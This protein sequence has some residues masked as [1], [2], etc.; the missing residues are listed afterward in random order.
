MNERSKGR[1][2]VVLGV[3]CM[4]Q[5][6]VIFWM[7]FAED[8]HS[9]ISVLNTTVPARKPSNLTSQVISGEPQRLTDT[10]SELPTKPAVENP[11]S[12]S[13]LSKLVGHSVFR[14]GSLQIN[15]QIAH[16]L[17]LSR[18]QIEEVND[19]LMRH[20]EDY[21]NASVDKAQLV[22]TPEGDTYFKISPSAELSN[23]GDRLRSNLTDAIG[24]DAGNAITGLAARS[25]FFLSLGKNSIDI[26]LDDI[27]NPDGVQQRYLIATI[28]DSASDDNGFSAH[29]LITP[30]AKNPLYE[31]LMARFSSQ[32]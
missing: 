6:T 20:A 14:A 24:V 9:Q 28:G 1:L 23:L 13:T 5:T 19:I 15:P 31:S 26:Y 12:S 27:V 3:V 7:L 11:V 16:S 22:K 32:L 18:K 2:L 10:H 4:A 8:R 30:G 29:Y 21:S 17:K 25:P